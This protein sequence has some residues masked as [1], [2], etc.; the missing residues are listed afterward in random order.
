MRRFSCLVLGLTTSIRWW[1]ASFGGNVIVAPLR[2]AL[3]LEG[4]MLKIARVGAAAL[5]VGSIATVGQA[6]DDRP[7]RPLPALRAFPA[8]TYI[9]VISGVQDSGGAENAGVA[10]TIHCTNWTVASQQIR[11]TVKNFNGATVA[12]QTVGIGGGVTV[13]KSTHGSAIT[14]D[15]PHFSPGVAINQGS[16][17]IEATAAQV[18]CTAQV[19]DAASAVPASP[20]HSVRFNPWPNSQE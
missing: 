13:T 6:A 10:T 1:Q 7:G 11:F 16:V 3:L 2:A 5:L 17:A 15:L 4:V 19:R 9:Y 20:L 14:E 12:T 18:T 8:L